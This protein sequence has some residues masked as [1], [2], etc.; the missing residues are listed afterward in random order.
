MKKLII[1]DKVLK[2]VH[3]SVVVINEL[4]E[5]PLIQHINGQLYFQP[6]VQRD[7]CDIVDSKSEY[8]LKRLALAEERV[9]SNV[10]LY[11]R[12][13]L[14]EKVNNDMI[15]IH[16]VH[17]IIGSTREKWILG[18][19]VQRE[20]ANYYLEDGTLSVRVSFTDLTWADPEAFFTENCILLCSGI[21]KNNMFM[22]NKMMHP[23]LH[24]RKQFHYK[25]NE[26]D[27]FGSYTK[28]AL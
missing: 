9:F 24:H 21:Y 16:N 23:P 5:F 19:L 7:F 13:K 6:N 4:Q 1:Q 20:D 26:V 10:N 2:K 3:E 15:T 22:I 27:Y 17:S 11:Q 28:K 14:T 18:L 12:A 25:L 8:Y